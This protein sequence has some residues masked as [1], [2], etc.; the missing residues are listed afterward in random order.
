MLSIG[1]LYIT[2]L[3][4]ILSLAPTSS[5]PVQEIKYLEGHKFYEVVHSPLPFSYI[6]EES[7]PESFSWAN[8]TGKSYITA[9]VNQHLPHYCGSCW[10]QGT[11]SA[12]AD[13]IKIARI[14]ANAGDVVSS[15]LRNRQQQQ[16]L[17]SPHPQQQQT[18]DDI[19]LSVQFVLNCGGH[20]AGSCHGGSASG[21]YEFIH[22]MGFI[23]YETCQSYIACSSDSTIG[24]CSQVD[25]T[26]RP[27]NIC[28]TCH[29]LS[30]N[31]SCQALDF[32]PNATVAEY[33]II[34]EGNVHAIQAEILARGPVAAEVNGV[35]LHNY[36]GGIIT[37]DGGEKTTTHI[38]SIIGW[39]VESGIRHWIVRNS[40]GQYWGEM[41]FFRVEL[42]KNL[43]GIES[44]I[45]WATPGNF[46][47]CTLPYQ[48]KEM[49]C[50]FEIYSD[51]SMDIESIRYRFRPMSSSGK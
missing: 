39:G 42:G 19:L 23:P 48:G 32:F 37:D 47:T 4:A 50:S 45:I 17:A 34:H 1:M 24:F 26:C 2:I 12:L 25:T 51:P 11:L 38:V 13:R 30:N 44:K 14:E 28:R 20:I 10:A 27:M 9:T 22:K 5:L 18:Q 3:S 40:W 29:V 15:K 21:T 7:L 43:L 31:N 46:T 33:G 36:C 41:G 8:H 6:D 35:L 16:Q 49:Q